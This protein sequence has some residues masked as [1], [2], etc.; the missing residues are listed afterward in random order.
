M[1][2]WQWVFV[3]SCVVLFVVPTTFV[4]HSVYD[5]GLVG[6]LGL[7]GLAS[8][9]FVILGETVTGNGYGI[10][11]EVALLVASFAIFLCWHLWRF[12]RRVL[13]RTKKMIISL[14]Q[15]FGAKPHTEEHEIAAG[16]LLARVNALLEGLG[17][18]WPIDPDTGCAI[19]GSRGGSGDGGFRLPTATTGAAMSSHKQARAVDVYD[20]DDYL[21]R[22]ITDADLERHGLYREHPDATRG[23][24]HLT[25][26]A[27]GSGKRTFW[28]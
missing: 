26:R 13:R 22:N 14:T 25:T 3:L 15:Y 2:I 11:A 12:H 28:P 17:W 9:A 18:D 27:P 6:R 4:W 23:W 24:C 5:D 19:S 8:F 10:D 1:G 21:D 16:D 20:P 7:V